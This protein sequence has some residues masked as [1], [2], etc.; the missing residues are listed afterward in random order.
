M[1]GEPLFFATA[2]TLGGYAQPVVGTTFEGRPTKLG[3]NPEHPFGGGA[4]DAFTQA[5]ILSLY[6]PDRSRTVLRAG[7]IANWDDLPATVADETRRV[8]GER[9]QR[10]SHPDRRHHLADAPRGEI[11]ALLD[12]YPSARLARLRADLARKRVRRDAARLRPA[13]GAALSLRPGAHD[14]IARRRL[15]RARPAAGRIR[16]AVSPKADAR[17]SDSDD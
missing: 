11:A 4:T 3:P 17:A 15:P 2:L 9:G 13:A 16:D 6:D 10:P 12:D 1:P 14:R 5:A 7:E 8:E